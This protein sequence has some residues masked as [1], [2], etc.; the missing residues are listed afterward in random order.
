MHFRVLP[1]HGRGKE[2]DRNQASVIH[3]VNLLDYKLRLQ[4]AILH[5]STPHCRLGAVK[6]ICPVLMV[7]SGDLSHGRAVEV[8][9][10]RVFRSA[11]GPGKIQ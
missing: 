10:F 5:S 4:A 11:Q 6:E 1:L 3:D 8:T 2:Q 9:E 7:L